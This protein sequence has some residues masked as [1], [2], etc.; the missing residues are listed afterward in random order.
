MKFFETLVLHNLYREDL[1]FDRVI[2][3]FIFI[4]IIKAEIF[5]WV[6][7]WNSHPIRNQSERFNLVTGVLNDL[8]RGDIIPAHGFLLDQRM[9]RIFESRVVD[10]GKLYILL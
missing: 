4:P 5:K 9:H 2:I 10:Y 1:E 8:Y 3:A 6:D 7:D